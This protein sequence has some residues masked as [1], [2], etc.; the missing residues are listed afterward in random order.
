MLGTDSAIIEQ[1]TSATCNWQFR[2]PVKHTFGFET[3]T[4]AAMNV[5]NQNTSSMRARMKQAA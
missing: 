1:T 4:E 2:E 5:E 3:V